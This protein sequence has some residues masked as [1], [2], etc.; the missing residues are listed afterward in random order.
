MPTRGPS[1]GR[2]SGSSTSRHPPTSTSPDRTG[3]AS[4]ELADPGDDGAASDAV[5]LEE[6]PGRTAARDLADGE[7]VNLDVRVTDRLEDGGA[8]PAFR[9]VILDGQEARCAAAAGLEER[10]GIDGL[11]AVEIDHAHRDTGAG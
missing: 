3:L 6:L 2:S 1:G 9:V 8:Q 10:R 11:H 4:D 5:T 7:P